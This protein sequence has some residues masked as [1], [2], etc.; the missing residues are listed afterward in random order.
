MKQKVGFFST[1]FMINA[2]NAT[3]FAV[4]QLVDVTMGLSWVGIVWL[5]AMY[6]Y[7][8]HK[9][10]QKLKN[11]QDDLQ[12]KVQHREMSKKTRQVAA[13][14]LMFMTI[15]LI[16]LFELE[17]AF[18]YVLGKGFVSACVV[19]PWAHSYYGDEKRF[20]FR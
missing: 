9:V 19:I 4:K 16:L 11:N 14:G 5:F 1:D 13:F 10:S 12:A 2:R 17:N 6:F 8:L 20:K 15:S 18:L 3:S 7:N